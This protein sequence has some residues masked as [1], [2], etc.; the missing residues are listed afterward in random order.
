[1]I[2]K[3]INYCWFGKASLPPQVQRCINS[4]Q[5]YCPDYTI[6]QWNESNFDV[7][8][9]SFTK[10]AYE[11]QQ[12]AFVSDVARLDIIYHYGGIYLDTDVELIKSLD[13]VLAAEAYFG[14]EDRFTVNT[15]GG[16][17]GVKGNK[18][19][20]ANLNEYQRL[21]FINQDGT[22]NQVLCTDITTHL[23]AKSGFKFNGSKQKIGNVIIYPSSYFCPVNFW[24]QKLVIKP[25][26]IS[27][28]HYAAS[29]KDEKNK[30]K[31]SGKVLGIK[32]YLKHY[33]DFLWGYGTYNSLK[34]LIK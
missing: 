9:Y 22:F 20:L 17:G 16:F 32:K 27:I 25:N 21:H 5:K 28:H 1:M 2:P 26:T 13:S 8:K 7:N 34:R 31:S 11:R 14:C 3:V 4:W 29:W 30:S 10:E 12:W 15:G 6:I 24:R 33:I 18:F 19:I 23:L